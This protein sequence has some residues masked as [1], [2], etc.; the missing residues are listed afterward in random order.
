M[1]YISCNE[2]I[3]FCYKCKSI[4]LFY[5]EYLHSYVIVIKRSVRLVVVEPEDGR[6]AE[7]TVVHVDLARVVVCVRVPQAPDY[8]HPFDPA[9]S[10]YIHGFSKVYL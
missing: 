9:Q 7:E 3:I 4:R 5:D 8:I 10:D 2:K 1:Y 6:T